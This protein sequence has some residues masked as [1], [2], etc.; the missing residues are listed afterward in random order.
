[1]TRKLQ[2][3]CH[4]SMSS[5][6]LFIRY[7]RR[8]KARAHLV[9]VTQNTAA[10]ST[11]E[12]NSPWRPVQRATSRPAPSSKAVPIREDVG[13]CLLFRLATTSSSITEQVAV[14]GHRPPP[15]DSPEGGGGPSWW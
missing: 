9:L 8:R 10:V 3:K 1:M 4:E 2:G 12:E 13:E 14:A 7:A 5:R 11:V 6:R 15:P